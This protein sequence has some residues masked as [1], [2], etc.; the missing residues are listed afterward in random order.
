MSMRKQVVV[1]SA[2]LMVFALCAGCV[3]RKVL[4]RSE[5]SGVLAWVDEKRVGSTP[6]DLTFSHYGRRKIRVG[7]VRGSGGR[8]QWLAA[9][10][11][12]EIKAPWYQQYPLD[13]FFEVLWPWTMVDEHEVRIVLPAATGREYLYGVERAEE[14]R[15]RAEQFKRKAFTPVPELEQ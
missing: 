6:V 15:E 12:V 2:F 14:V 9:E 8:I 3:E 11:M 10:R 13:F 4:I 5:P 1:S 7:P